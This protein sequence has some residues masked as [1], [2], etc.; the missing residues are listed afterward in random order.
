MAT[1]KIS[2]KQNSLSM[3][4][5]GIQIGFEASYQT[6]QDQEEER[7]R[8]GKKSPNDQR[9]FVNGLIKVRC[10]DTRMISFLKLLSPSSDTSY[11]L[12]IMNVTDNNPQYSLNYDHETS[13]VDFINQIPKKENIL[14][15]IYLSKK[16][17]NDVLITAIL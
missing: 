3:F 8:K 5:Q 11:T 17:N 9:A 6:L 16:S 14:S 2:K 1:S 7:I 12:C 4:W 13:W 15:Q 10:T